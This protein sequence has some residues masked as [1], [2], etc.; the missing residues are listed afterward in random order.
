[1]L[2]GQNSVPL[3]DLKDMLDAVGIKVP[4]HKVRDIT[5]QLKTN[6][7]AEG[8]HLSKAAFEKVRNNETSITWYER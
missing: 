3:G 6:N 4:N 8:E 5:T 7:Q 1:M 2:G